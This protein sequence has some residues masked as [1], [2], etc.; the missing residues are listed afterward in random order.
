[1]QTKNAE[2]SKVIIV[3]APNV[4]LGGGLSLLQALFSSPQIAL[5]KWVQLDQRAKEKLQL[6][7]DVVSHYV[8]HSFQSRFCA[9]WRLW[10]YTEADDI[11]LC[12]HGLPPLFPLRGRVVLF[13]QNRILI[14]QNAISGYP[15]R[16]KSRLWLERL[17]LRTC[18]FF[19][20]KFIVQT[21]SM[22]RDTKKMLGDKIDIV[23]LPFVAQKNCEL[24]TQEIAFE[25]VYVASDEAH[26]NHVNLLEAWCLLA[27]AGLKPSLALTV[28]RK[29]VLS[30]KIKD[31]NKE[32]GLNIRNFGTLPT[33]EIHRLYRSSV[34]LIY[35]SITESLG[36]PLIEAAQHG[37]PILA[38]EM[39]YVRDVVDPV[40]T[41]DPLSPVSIARAVRRFLGKPEPTV[42]MRTPE[43]FLAEILK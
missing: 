24:D 39:D 22:A 41:F 30:D 11:V 34:A 3:H 9:E 25:F 37:L 2:L 13:L 12:F 15:L 17:V 38:P 19:V 43:D 35:P 26:K 1:M 29:S 21:P 20:D 10:R 36:L 8:N 28:P 27:E 5:F 23:V 16:T 18:S 4:H 32:N 6:P 7:I 42:S 40:Q 33:S 14:N 31:Y